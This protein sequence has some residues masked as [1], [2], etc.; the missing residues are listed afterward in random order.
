M[1]TGRSPCLALVTKMTFKKWVKCL[2]IRHKTM[3][4]DDS[5]ILQKIGV[6]KDNLNNPKQF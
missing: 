2:N 6:G 3:K 1:F 4:L 5:T